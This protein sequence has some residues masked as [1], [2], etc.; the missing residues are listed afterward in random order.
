MLID[1]KTL[2]VGTAINT[3]VCVIG[4][5]PAGLTLA[6]EFIGQGFQVCLLE[7]GGLEADTETQ[8]LCTGETIGDPYSELD[9]LRRRQCGGTA[10]DWTVQITPTQKGVRYGVLDEVDFEQRD[11]LPYSGWPF[12]RSHLEPFY[13]RAQSI[14]KIGPFKYEG[15]DWQ[16]GNNP[17][18]PL[19]SK[20]L[21][22]TVFQF[23]PSAAFTQ[24]HRDTAIKAKNIT[25]YLNANAVELETDEGAKAVTRVRFVCFPGKQFW[26]SAKMVI[27]ATGGLENARLLLLSDQTQKSG[28]GNQNDLVGRFFMDHP[29]VRTGDFIP[30]N[31]HIFNQT[32]L[33][34]RCQI[35]KTLV[36]GKL[37]LSNSVMRH[38]KVLNMSAML[39]PRYP[40]IQSEAIRSLK[41]LLEGAKSGRLPEDTRKHLRN[42]NHGVSDFT[43]A[44]YRTLIEKPL[45][46]AIP[47]DLGHGGWSKF[48]NKE[49]KFG[50]FEVY[51][52]TEQAPHPDNRVTLSQQL[53]QLGSRKIKLHWQWR[54]ID[55]DNVVRAQAILAEEIQYAGLGKLLI[56]RQEE[57]PFLLTPTTHHHIGTTRMHVDAKLGVVN[58]SCQV[59]GVSNLF[60]AGSSVFPTGGY[61]NPTLTIVALAVRLADHIKKVIKTGEAAL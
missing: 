39:F 17:E 57:R 53:D 47:A 45:R 33:Y 12:N 11:W 27:L 56:D 41:T 44:A 54:S 29:L 6:H 24:E 46:P 18:L 2:P 9:I 34:N 35:N 48:K 61:A 55:I 58:E 4:T 8:S 5:G 38:E 50:Y 26:V 59:H 3:D 10:N 13:E 51:S 32:A 7:S 36:M 60:V 49:R 52:Q 25:V 43:A 31:R 20:R 21:T 16:N 19:A 1:A 40:L 37:S 15:T 30:S 23:G 42:V 28:L 14:C 22:T